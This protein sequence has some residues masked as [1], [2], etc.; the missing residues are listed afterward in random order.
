MSGSGKTF[1]PSHLAN[2]LARST[3]SFVGEYRGEFLD[4]FSVNA[5]LRRDDNDAFSD[6]TT[7]SLSGAWRIPGID[8][9]LHAS[10]GTG[11]TNPTFFEQFGYLPTQFI[12]NPGLLP[13]ES[14]GWDV[15]VEQG[16]F[17]GMLIVDLTYFNQDL[18]NEIATAYD[19]PLPTPVNLDGRSERQGV[20]V[21]AT[22]DLFNGFTATASYTYTD[23]TEQAVAGGPRLVEVRRPRHSGSLNAAYRFYDNRARVFG[24]V[25]VNGEMLD[26]D[27]STFP[28]SRVR[29]KPYTV[30]NVGGSFRFNETVEGFARIENLFD[31][32][33]E[34]VLGYNSQGLVAFFG[35]KG[36]F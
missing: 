2:K 4:Q 5:A 23:A 31:E 6:A 33:Y 7:Y 22:V 20:E 3:N 29:L 8:T 11:V 26:L 35:L 16:F 24:E 17:G 21:A 36:S 14:F 27:F 13:E 30:V 34:D 25:V 32:E 18:T 10:L 15:G 1:L 19:G 28:S 9:R 12:G